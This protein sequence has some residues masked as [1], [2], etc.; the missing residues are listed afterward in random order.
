MRGRG[1]RALEAGLLGVRVAVALIAGLSVE[2]WVYRLLGVFSLAGEGLGVEPRHRFGAGFA[3][4][5]VV[6]PLLLEVAKPSQSLRHAALVVLG[7]TLVLRRQ[8]C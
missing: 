2:E 3:P 1:V 7:G 6:V 8:D 4:L 5:V